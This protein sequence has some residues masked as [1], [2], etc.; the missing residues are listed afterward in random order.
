M[1]TSDTELNALGCGRPARARVLFT[2]HSMVEK[3][4]EGRRFSEVA[5]L[6]YRGSP[7]EV[8]IWDEAILPGQTLT[9]SRDTLASLLKPLRGHYPALTEAIDDLV[10]K[11][12]TEQDGTLSWLPDLGEQHGVD[13]NDALR[14]VDGGPSEQAAAVEALWFLF[15]KCVTIRRDGAYGNTMLDY[16]DTLP[17]DIKPLLALDASARVRTVYRF[18][19]DRR[20]G[21]TFLPEAVKRYDAHT[22]HVW[23]VAG[24]KSGF[25]KDGH[26]LVEGIAST[27]RSKPD[28]EWLVVHHKT[29]IKMDFETEVRTLLQDDGRGVHFLHWGAH[30]A[31]N[32]FA[33]V[34]NVILAG[35]LFL[36]TS[37]YEALG[38]LASGHP[39]ARGPFADEDTRKVT[40]G[41]HHH[42]ILQALCRGAVRRCVGGGCPPTDTYVIASRGSG[43]PQSLAA[44]FPG[45]RMV[46]WRPVAKA[47]RG[48]VAEAV[49]FICSATIWMRTAR[50]SG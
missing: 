10:T 38:R 31:T 9:I 32:K 6:H 11:L 21:I 49:A 40:L 27:I 46:P 7:R 30:D 29:G 33:H 48:K 16:R 47:L 37:Y 22:I 18:W 42:L 41:E 35:T 45:A 26:R 17:D 28:E 12:K 39:S 2:T 1:L 14:V 8:R 19:E 44:I 4:C 24:S 5:A 15:G 36:P 20:G 43:I 3:R 13:L 25:K 23:K 34:P 50:Q